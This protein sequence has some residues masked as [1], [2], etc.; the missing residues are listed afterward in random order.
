MKLDNIKK[1]AMDIPTL[2]DTSQSSKK[3]S[4][5]GV[6][7]IFK[8]KGE[9]KTATDLQ[10]DGRSSGG[11]GSVNRDIKQPLPPGEDFM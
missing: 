10:R 5:G 7:S 1:E 2:A 4:P 6:S 11:L 8:P 3:S 9:S